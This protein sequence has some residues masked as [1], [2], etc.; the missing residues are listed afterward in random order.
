[1]RIVRIENATRHKVLCE[2]CEVAD[3]MFTRMRGL[4]GKSTL[5]AGAG[6]LITPCPS[7][8]MFGMKFSLDVVFLT[9]ENIVTDMVENIAPGRYYVARPQ[10][11][12]AYS[13]LELP[14]GTINSTQTAVGDEVAIS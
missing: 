14:V 3:N 9:R 7:I 1:M 2:R 10:Q 5:A 8:H 4:L 13:A 6:L 11:G 12:K